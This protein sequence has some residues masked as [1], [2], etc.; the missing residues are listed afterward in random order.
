MVAVMALMLTG[1]SVAFAEEITV[2]D[3]VFQLERAE[4]EDVIHLQNGEKLSGEVLNDVFDV[5]T[6]YGP[7]SVPTAMLAGVNLGPAAGNSEVLLTV[8]YNRLSG[9][10]LDRFV[11][12][13]TG[14]NE[15]EVRK[16]EIDYI[17]FNKQAIEPDLIESSSDTYLFVMKNGDL[18]TGKA[19][20]DQLDIA[21]DGQVLTEFLAAAETVT[22]DRQQVVFKKSDD[23]IKGRLE[24]KALTLNLD[25]NTTIEDVY[26]GEIARVYSGNGQAQAAIQ[27]LTSPALQT[28]LDMSEAVWFAAPEELIL[29]G[30]SYKNDYVGPV[31]F[32]HKAHYVDYGVSCAI[33]HHWQGETPDTIWSCVECHRPD[34]KVGKVVKLADAYHMDCKGCHE[35]LTRRGEANA[36]Y[37]TCS[38]C[39]EE[40]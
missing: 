13:G 40:K 20:P 34:Q 16:E 28:G 3:V 12:I 35:Y 36:P 14:D 39:H 10:L 4:T 27:F 2:I 17:V 9:Y 22:M 7:V 18:L 29:D 31:S 1:G 32:S 8:N 33:C 19:I 21:Y 5:L 24:T 38:D 11:R 6:S 37:E 15:T 30:D 23:E 26:T 25:I